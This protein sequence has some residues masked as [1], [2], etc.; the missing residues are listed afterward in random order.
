MPL[1][2]PY[3]RTGRTTKMLH[4]SIEKL[5]DGCNVIVT[6]Y[7]FTYALDLQKDVCEMLSRHNVTFQTKK[8]IIM[9]NDCEMVFTKHFD[10][11]YYKVT[12]CA[13]INPLKTYIMFEDHYRERK[14][15][16]EWL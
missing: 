3:R 15:V 12:D 6:A 9:V 7:N 8:F 14:K 1:T 2:D 16:N 10:N 4:S 11:F 13:Y 5:M